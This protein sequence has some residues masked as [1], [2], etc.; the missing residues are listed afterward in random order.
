MEVWN[1][2]YLIINAL[3]WWVTFFY[4][5]YNHKQF[6]VGSGIL[7]MYATISTMAIHLFFSKR[8]NYLFDDL[9]FFPFIYLYLMIMIAT[10]PLTHL[11]YDK[12]R[13]IT[14]NETLLK[15]LCTLVIIATII[16]LPNLISQISNNFMLLLNNS[17]FGLK[18]YQKTASINMTRT[19]SQMNI[20]AIISNM[21]V[22]ISPMLLMFCL[23]FRKTSRWIVFVLII[24]TLTTPLS[25][26]MSGARFAASKTLFNLSFLLLFFYKFFNDKVKRRVKIYAVITAALII[27]PF[28]AIT[29]SRTHGDIEHTTLSIERYASESILNFNNHALDAGGTREGNYT[30]GVMKKLI[31]MDAKIYYAE[32]VRDYRYMSMNESIFYTFVGDFTLDYGP[33]PSVFIFI[34]TAI[35]FYQALRIKH[36]QMQF[37]QYVLFYAL[38]IGCLGY[39]QW[40]LG[41]IAGNL[42]LL[43]LLIIAFLFKIFP[44][45]KRM[46]NISKPCTI[47]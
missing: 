42:E 1:Y 10:Y 7:L 22:N 28:L 20:V 3:I 40:P 21:L 35:F 26:L 9:T 41:Q 29:I 39:F 19:E 17:D 31:G 8:F 6:N 47:H 38:L 34:F 23:Y 12:I 44:N 2:T 45:K 5:Q 32:R 18:T 27:T 15:I 24:A 36:H 30:A 13:R 16:K 33:I 37:Y 4:Y 11:Q 25:G 14:V 46:S 43:S